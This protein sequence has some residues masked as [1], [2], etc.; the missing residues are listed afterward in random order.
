MP[1]TVRR[2]VQKRSASDATVGVDASEG[3]PP[4]SFCPGT[5]SLQADGKVVGIAQR[6]RQDVALTAGLVV[7]RDHDAVAAVLSPVYDALGVPF[8][9][10]SV[11]SVARA[12]G[13]VD[14]LLDALETE[15]VGP[16][17]VTS[18][19]HIRDT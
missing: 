5:H 11:G 12:G 19:G 10:A 2:L 3:E 6:V 15:L 18:R 8:D 14:G 4:D 7:V 1:E 9:P 16:R 13:T 17:S